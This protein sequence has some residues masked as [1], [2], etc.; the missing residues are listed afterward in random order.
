MPTRKELELQR[1]E[2]LTQLVKDVKTL[3]E[4]VDEITK[5]CKDTLDILQKVMERASNVSKKG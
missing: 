3:K 2:E 4:R 5:V 1:A